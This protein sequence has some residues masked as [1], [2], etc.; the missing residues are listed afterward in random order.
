M[1]RPAETSAAAMAA[2]S[3]A[4]P[5][6]TM[7][8]SYAIVSKR[9]LL[10]NPGPFYRVR[11]GSANLRRSTGRAQDALRGVVEGLSL[12]GRLPT[13][14][15]G[16]L[17][18]VDQIRQHPLVSLEEGFHVHDEVLHHGEASDGFDRDPRGHVPDQDL[19]RQ[20]V[21]AIDEHG[22]RTADAVGTRPP[23]RQRA[24]VI[25][26]HHVEGVEQAVSWFHVHRELV[27]P[28]I[29]AH[30]GVEASDPER[31]PNLA[32]RRGTDPSRSPGLAGRALLPQRALVPQ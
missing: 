27:P 20:G 32:G 16:R 2:R 3:P 9:R 14:A 17:L 22:V 19:A 24:V 7:T 6:P 8:M 29:L 31:E 30:L 5:P 23:E 10:R 18:V 26:L 11:R 25:P 13:F 21:P 28:R 15:V 1:L 12:F 4:A